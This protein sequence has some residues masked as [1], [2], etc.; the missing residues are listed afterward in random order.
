MQYTGIALAAVL[1]SNAQV[2]A[3]ETAATP[4][5]IGGETPH[6]SLKFFYSLT[7]KGQLW[8][9]TSPIRIMFNKQPMAIEKANAVATTLVYIYINILIYLT[10]LVPS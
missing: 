6:R 9:I 2:P 5:L 10:S 7:C 1:F 3:A 4:H 8:A